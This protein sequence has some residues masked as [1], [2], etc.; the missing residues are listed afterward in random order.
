MSRRLMSVAIALLLG[1]AGLVTGATS[2]H[3]TS[4][5]THITPGFS[6]WTKEYCEDG[7]LVRMNRLTFGSSVQ[8]RQYVYRRNGRLCVFV[9]DHLAG[10]HHIRLFAKYPGGGYSEDDGYY[11]NYAG[12][13]AAPKGRTLVANGTL[14]LGSKGYRYFGTY[15]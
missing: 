8:G 14:W 4:Y 11:T 6:L 15:S 12:A 7:R 5:Y 9:V 2:A 10:S 13:F 3:A 1:I